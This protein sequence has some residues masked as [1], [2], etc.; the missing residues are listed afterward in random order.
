MAVV[1]DEERKKPIKKKGGIKKNKRKQ[2]LTL[3]K[4]AKLNSN[5][6]AVGKTV[7]GPDQ[8]RNPLLIIITTS[9]IIIIYY[10]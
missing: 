1:K 8:T 3:Q 2:I 10:N 5:I 6:K 4:E 9:K 7:D